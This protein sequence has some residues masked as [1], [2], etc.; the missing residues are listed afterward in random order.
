MTSFMKD[1]DYGKDYKYA[2]DFQNSKTSMECLPEKIMGSVFYKPW[3]ILQED[4]W[5]PPHQ[6]WGEI[7]D[8]SRR[9]L[10]FLI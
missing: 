6:L 4:K 7:K 1:L 2:H 10:E 9:D 3:A 8:V 5:K